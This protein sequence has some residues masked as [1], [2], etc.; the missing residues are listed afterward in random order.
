M[1][2]EGSVRDRR[3]AET[4][5]EIKEAALGQ[6][7][8][9]GPGGM[10]LRGVA[11]AVGM[12]VQSLYHYFGS[13]DALL[14]ALVVDAHNALADAVQAAADATRG[15]P[16]LE[17]RLATTGAYRHWAL[18]NRAAF[19]LLYGTPVPGFEPP[20]DAVG[21]AAFRLAGPFLDTTFDGWTREQLA[22]VPLPPATGPI[23]DLDGIKIPLPPGALALFIELRAQMHGLVMLELLGHLYPFG[24]HAEL[25]FQGAM[26]RS[27]ATLEALRTGQPVFAAR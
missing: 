4:V 18:A 6:L 25:L 2:V 20:A 1:S 8:E 15:R 13:R 14:T 7:A 24:E 21:A 26:Q 12:T 16:A 9:A 27:S 23:E 5:A 22:A 17:R 11:R 10:S 3:R 19:L